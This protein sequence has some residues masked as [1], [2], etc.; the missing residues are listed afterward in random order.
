MA[1]NGMF[2]VFNSQSWFVQTPTVWRAPLQ[3]GTRGL[4]WAFSFRR[5]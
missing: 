1:S 5:R 4:P 3:W 2:V